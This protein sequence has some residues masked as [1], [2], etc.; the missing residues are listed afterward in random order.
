MVATVLKQKLSRDQF[1]TWLAAVLCRTV[2][3][4][5]DHSLYTVLRRLKEL[6]A[7][8]ITTNYD[9]LLEQ[10]IGSLSLDVNDGTAV[11]DFFTCVG[12]DDALAQYV[13]HVHGRYDRPEHVVLD[14]I[15]YQRISEGQGEY[16][17]VRDRMRQLLTTHTVLF[18]PASSMSTIPTVTSSWRRMR[19]SPHSLFR[20]SSHSDPGRALHKTRSLR[21]CAR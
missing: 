5:T 2:H 18:S 6:G 17:A 7:R 12:V 13:F 16:H 8:F 19:H 14:N 10:E 9:M 11:H 4:A 3:R 20:A 1:N 21:H 15:D